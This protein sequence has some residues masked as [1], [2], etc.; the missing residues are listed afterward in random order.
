MAV[1]DQYLGICVIDQFGSITPTHVFRTLRAYFNN[2]ASLGDVFTSAD[3]GFGMNGILQSGLSLKIACEPKKRTESLIFFPV[4]QSFRDFKT[5][6][7]FF[8]AV[9]VGK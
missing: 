3:S 9:E 7:R 6:F 1:C 2:E 5:S 8:G 4:A